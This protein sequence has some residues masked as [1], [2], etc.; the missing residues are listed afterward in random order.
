MLWV[1]LSSAL[2]FFAICFLHLGSDNL[3]ALPDNDTLWVGFLAYLLLR[4]LLLGIGTPKLLQSI[5][6]SS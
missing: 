2:L 4:G 6:K 1:T 5:V 3:F